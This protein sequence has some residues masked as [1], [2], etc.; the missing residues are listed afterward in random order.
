MKDKRKQIII[1]IVVVALFTIFLFFPDNDEDGSF[2]DTGAISTAEET[3]TAASATDETMSAEEISKA[4]ALAAETTF[5]MWE[6]TESGEKSIEYITLCGDGV[7]ILRIELDEHDPVEETGTYRI[8]NSDGTKLSIPYKQKYQTAEING[9]ELT[10][11]G[12]TFKR[13]SESHF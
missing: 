10:V 8:S 7:Y 13:L 11:A 2:T 4:E 6:G 1:L 3:E 12:K 5:W 9:D